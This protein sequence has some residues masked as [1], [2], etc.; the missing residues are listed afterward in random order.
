MVA[1]R[2]GCNVLSQP[3]GAGGN[4]DAPRVW[5]GEQQA[6]APGRGSFPTKWS[7]GLLFQNSA[8]HRMNSTAGTGNRWY[9]KP[10]PVGADGQLASASF[11]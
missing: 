3:K 8:C 5:R 6:G 11:E 2:S 7:P 9:R 4:A 10:E 1:G